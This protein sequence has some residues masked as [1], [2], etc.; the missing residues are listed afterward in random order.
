MLLELDARCALTRQQLAQVGGDVVCTVSREEALEV[1]R[2]AARLDEARAH[3]GAH[4]GA[5]LVSGGVSG[6]YG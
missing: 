2:V 5:H 6:G 4:T 1:S 3:P